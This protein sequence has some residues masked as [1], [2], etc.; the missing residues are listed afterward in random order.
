MR[1]IH[2]VP[3]SE[4]HEREGTPGVMVHQAP[5]FRF[6]VSR[7]LWATRLGRIVVFEGNGYRLRF[8]PTALSA[9]LWCN[10]RFLARDEAVLREVLRPGDTFVD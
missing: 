8:Y 6:V 9:T 4:L 3:Q 2:H 7:A 10:R 1:G 5:A